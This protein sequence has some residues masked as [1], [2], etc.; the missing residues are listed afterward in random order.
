M[1]KFRLRTKFLLS[2][3]TITAGLTAATLL[4]VSY[5]VRNRVRENIRS[6]LRNSVA[7]YQ[8]FE[9][10]QEDALTRS[11]ILVANLPNVRA[12][13]TSGDAATIQDASADVWM[14]SGSDLLVLANRSGNII[15][16]RANMAGLDPATAQGQLRGSLDRGDSISWWF[17]GG[18]L[19]DVRIQPIYFGR[20]SQNTAIGLLALGHEV[21]ENA[22]QE[23]A[24][25]SQS[26]VAFNF[27]N[28]LVASTLS[29][30]Q[31]SELALKVRADASKFIG[32]SQ[33]IQL[34]SERYLAE[35][36]SLS[37]EGGPRVF[38]TVLESFDKATQFLN[39]LHRVLI[40]LGLLS[41]LAGSGLVFWISHT[42]TQPLSGLVAGVRAL[43]QGDFRYPLVSSGSDEVTEVTDAFIRMR[44]SLETTQ[45][46]QTQLEERLRQAHKMEAVGRLAG[47]IAHDFN[48]LLT[49]IRG[50][51]DL[52]MDR[53]G[54]DDFHRKCVGQIQ[55]A[56]SRAVSMTRQL[57][58]FSRM[59]VLQ[60]R[61]IDLNIVV[62]EM[63]KMLPRLIGEHIEYS[64]SPDPKLAAVK[65][66]PGQIEQV[67]LNLAANAR[68]AMPRGGK[69]IV[70]TSNVSMSSAQAAKRPPMTPGRYTL[71]TV[72][73]TGFGMD[74]A[75]IAHIFEPFFTTKE[76]GK[77]TGLGLATV[78]GIVKQ[79][80]G[81]IWVESDPGQGTRFEIYLPQAGETAVR[82]ETR[83]S[84]AAIPEGSETIL[85]VEDE[86]GVREL[87]CQFLRVKGY[88]VLSA[89]GGFEAL[90]V[91]RCHSGEIHLLLTDMI[92]PRMNGEDLA[93]QL[94]VIRPEIRIAFMSGYS[95]FSRGDLGRTFPEAP[96]L[97]KPFSPASLVEIVRT[98]LDRPL[99]S[100]VRETSESRV[101]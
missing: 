5:S 32:D 45:Q 53:E 91:A 34:G 67:V 94:K 97:Q 90:D 8:S 71:L 84:P 77:G 50:N 26:E 95:E 41:I 18:H 39:D 60:P 85:V 7:N 70:R 75:T 36:V 76:I 92:M 10:Q 27:E 15:A 58:A 68:D 87:A 89:G 65:A 28:T 2:L 12:L 80:D 72:S 62:A 56:S 101:S 48:N 29:R 73:D 9:A 40:G 23:F 44:A 64:F 100:A 22:A 69:L 11:A 96:M 42:F 33:E 24:S 51:S 1:I 25:V 31:Q 38:L 43:G 93:V 61:V 59:Q 54:A 74:Q 78:Y 4:I 16:L 82:Q 63:G 14:I 55:K 81:F 17:A 99:P 52:L 13:M 21:D 66:D 19:Y 30:A 47:G 46:E 83:E 98:A 3:L 6:D 35:T 57:L 49:I 86:T 37:P 88:N 20:S 79:S